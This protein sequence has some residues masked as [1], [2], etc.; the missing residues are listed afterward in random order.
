MIYAISYDLKKAGQDYSGLIKAIKS[1]G[2]SWAHPCESYWLVD[3]SV[4]ANAIFARLKPHVDANDR[5]LVTRFNES[6]YSGWLSQEIWDWI[7][8]RKSLASSLYR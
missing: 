5:M 3:C 4:N 2:S 7:S 1:L 8:A 6:D